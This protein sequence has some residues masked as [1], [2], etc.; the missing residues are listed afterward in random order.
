MFGHPSLHCFITTAPPS[1]GLCGGWPA[2]DKA[3]GSVRTILL[4]CADTMSPFLL[5]EKYCG[6]TSML[7]FCR[8]TLASS[9]KDFCGMPPSTSSTSLFG[10]STPKQRLTLWRL[11]IWK[12]PGGDFFFFSTLLPLLIYIPYF[13]C[14]HV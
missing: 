2:A 10:I 5:N 11:R 7:Q 9:S 8:I 13:Y 6:T 3:S 12:T 1:F 14:S 4:F